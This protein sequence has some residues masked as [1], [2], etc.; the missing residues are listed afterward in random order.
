MA[1]FIIFDCYKQNE[2]LKSAPLDVRL[3]F[4]SREYVPSKTPALRFIM[5]DCTIQYKPIIDEVKNM[6]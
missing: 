2:M 5:H 3:E 1:S 6:T 4:E